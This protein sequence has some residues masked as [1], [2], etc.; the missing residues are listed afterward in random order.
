MCC[1]HHNQI[2]DKSCYSFLSQTISNSFTICLLLLLLVCSGE[3]VS[4]SYV[5]VSGVLLFLSLCAW[6]PWWCCSPFQWAT[7]NQCL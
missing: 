4:C 1:T 3:V 6:S 7:L 5:H 2:N